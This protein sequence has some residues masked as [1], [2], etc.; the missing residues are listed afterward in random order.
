MARQMHKLL[1]LN[2]YLD[3]SIHSLT[4]DADL[5]FS[6]LW[7][8]LGFLQFDLGLMVRINWQVSVGT[9]TMTFLSGNWLF[10]TKMMTRKKLSE[11]A[12]LDLALVQEVYEAAAH[13]NSR[14][15]TLHGTIA[16]ECGGITTVFAIR[17]NLLTSVKE[18]FKKVN[19]RL[20]EPFI[21]S[22]L[23]L[24]FPQT[25]RENKRYFSLVIGPYRCNV[26]PFA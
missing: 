7:R 1:Y 5:S 12:I 3:L 20:L 2:F 17:T 25:I 26:A 16:C 6:K 23:C 19:K 9:L 18:V 21:W 15:A 22:L 4:A 8:N 14:V 13:W 10:P 24:L 11:S